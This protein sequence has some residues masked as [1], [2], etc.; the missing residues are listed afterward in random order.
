MKK[1]GLILLAL[2][3]CN[4]TFISCGR[5]NELPITTGP[6]NSYVIYVDGTPIEAYT[7]PRVIDDGEGH[8]DPGTSPYRNP[9]ETPLS[10]LEEMTSQDNGAILRFKVNRLYQNEVYEEAWSSNDFHCYAEVTV[11]YVYANYSDKEIAAGDVFS[12]K[13]HHTVIQPKDADAYLLTYAGSQP[14]RPG[15]SYICFTRKFYEE[16]Y[17]YPLNA[18][19]NDVGVFEL[20]SKESRESFDLARKDQVWGYLSPLATEVFKKYAPSILDTE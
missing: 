5:S 17:L 12:V 19:L 18:Y 13:Q 6:G 4:M 14:L 16:G 11:E 7:L 15:F 3:I 1:I 2:L 20:S 9:K 8:G 10:V